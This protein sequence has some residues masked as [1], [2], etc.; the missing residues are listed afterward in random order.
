M[1]PLEAIMIVAFSVLM[2]G[3]ALPVLIRSGHQYHLLDRPGR[4]K[5]HKEPVPFLGG[6]ALFV[7]IWL[8]VA[9]LLLV[10]PA[11]M[12][13]L[14]GMLPYIL[15]GAMLV[16][17]I[18]FIDD[19][20]SLPAWVK[21]GVE[22]MAGVVLYMGG[23]RIDPVSIPFCGQVEVGE[24]SLVITVLWVV[25]LT[26][27]INLIDGLDGLAG[28]VSLIG[29]L[30]LTAVGNLYH[31]G[32]TLVFA[33]ALIGFLVIFLRYNRYPARIFLG[34]SGSLQI[35]YYFAVLSLMVPLKSFTA[36]ALYLPL[37][38]LGVPILESITSTARRLLRRK[39]VMRAD[40]RHLFH[41][42]ALAG[43]TP[44]QIVVIFWLVSL[45]F[46]LFSLAMFFWDRILVF[47]FLVLFMVVISAAFFIFVSGRSRTKRRS[48][49]T[50]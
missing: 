39:S 6:V 47:S 29:A 33:Y 4:H 10:F 36:A 31:I 48:G 15:A 42:L 14:S 43:L 46:G 9:F 11:S 50:L 45:A 13:E 18:G 3:V 2:S 37:M 44:R 23:L 41:Y 30:T 26:N 32:V 1:S 34:D 12:A 17:G 35:G 16:G 21:L 40:R 19:L 5:R 24:F 27:S 8:T 7:A 20:R 28:G 25:G 38:A 49:K 22:V